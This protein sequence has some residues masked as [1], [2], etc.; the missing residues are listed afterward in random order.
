DVAR[1]NSMVILRPALFGLAQLHQLRGRVGRGPVQAYCHLLTA[2]GED[3]SEDARKRL[4][5]LQAMDRL[6]AG[7]AISAAD[8][9]RRG[10]GELL[11]ERQAGHLQRVGL[12]L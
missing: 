11:G 1:A 12:G 6:G 2:E 8:L 5:T 10:S 7:T 4:G 9:D 3:L